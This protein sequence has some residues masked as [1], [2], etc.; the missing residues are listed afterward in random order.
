VT[1]NITEIY[2]AQFATFIAFYDDQF[3]LLIFSF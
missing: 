1:G 2:I 3:C